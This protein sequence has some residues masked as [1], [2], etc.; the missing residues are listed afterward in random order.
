MHGSWSLE[1]TLAVDTHTINDPF[2]YDYPYAAHIV[3]SM[4]CLHRTPTPPPIL[5]TKRQGA[6]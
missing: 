3:Y 1:V 5:Y 4:T 6:I 2:L